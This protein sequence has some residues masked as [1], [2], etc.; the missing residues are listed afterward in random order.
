MT[1]GYGE[2]LHQAWA[3]VYSNAEEKIF[4]LWPI[5]DSIC[6]CPNGNRPL[7]DPRRC[8]S[9][10]KHPLYAPAHADKNDPLR[11]VCKY[12]GCGRVGHGLY[13]ATADPE[14]NAERWRRHPTAGIGLPAQGNGYAIIDVDPRHGGD[15]SFWQLNAQCLARGVDLSSTVAQFSGEYGNS[16][17]VHYLFRAPEGGVKGRA[18][19]F[20]PDLPG[21]DLRGRGHYIVVA[22]TVHVSGVEYEWVDWLADA[23]PWPEILNRI[24]DPPK[25]PPAPP[26]FRTGTPGGLGYANVALAREVAAVR[27]TGEGNRNNALNKSAYYLGQLVAG[28]EL[29]RETVRAELKAAAESIGLTAAAAENTIES[30]F[31]AGAGKPRTRPEA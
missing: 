27:S 9:P 2:T 29:D 20:G 28:G 6:S 26:M 5:V 15:E 8:Q 18:N 30:G 4:P 11:G 12:G 19:A 24:I 21:L 25:A 14:I 22:P 1:A 10:G 3:R 31:T 17:G 7:D 23:A 13:D 16:R